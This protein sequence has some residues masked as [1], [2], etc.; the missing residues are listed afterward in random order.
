LRRVEVMTI[1]EIEMLIAAS[2]LRSG[3]LIGSWGGR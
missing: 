3:V 2:G 1:D